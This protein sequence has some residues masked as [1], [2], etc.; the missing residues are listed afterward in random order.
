MEG[1]CSMRSKQGPSWRKKLK[2]ICATVAVGSRTARITCGVVAPGVANDRAG[3]TYLNEWRVIERA[4]ANGCGNFSLAR[5]CGIVQL[6]GRWPLTVNK[7]AIDPDVAADLYDAVLR[8]AKPVLERASSQAT[9]IESAE[10]MRELNCR[11]R[12]RLEACKHEK[13]R[14]DPAHEKGTHS[15]QGEERDRNPRKRKHGDTIDRLGGGSARIEYVRLEKPSPIGELKAPRI[16]LNVTNPAVSEARDKQNV[17]ATLVIAMALVANAQAGGDPQGHL[18]YGRTEQRSFEG[19]LG[20][21]L[22]ADVI[23]DGKP[24]LRVV[25]T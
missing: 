13:E 15:R 2:P 23:I 4:S 14:R 3:F 16:M 24:T 19:V 22:N 12:G 5:F 1:L 10:F 18:F 25:N 9:V 20:D 17:E 7:D 6:D 21:L 8:A 11:L